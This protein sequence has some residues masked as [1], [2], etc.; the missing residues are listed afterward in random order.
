MKEKNDK[1]GNFFADMGEFMRENDADLGIVLPPSNGFP[2]VGQEGG[3]DLGSPEAAGDPEPGIVAEED[4][5]KNSVRKERRSGRRPGRPGR[6][7]EP[8]RQQRIQIFIPADLYLKYKEYL[9]HNRLSMR[10]DIYRFI[11]KQVNGYE[12]EQRS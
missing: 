5:A 4:A 6:M 8:A 7:A 2:E 1:R 3:T 12:K 11:K 9:F 10:E